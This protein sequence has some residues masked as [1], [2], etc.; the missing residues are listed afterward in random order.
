MKNLCLF[1]LSFLISTTLFSQKKAEKKH[2]S[3]IGL[4]IT[5]T[6]AGFFNAGGD[7]LPKDPFLFS[8]KRL[9]GGGAIRFGTNFRIVNQQ[10]FLNTGGQQ[11]S[12]ENDFF[13]RAGYEWRTSINRRFTLY[14]GLDGLLEYENETTTISDFGGENLTSSE[15]IYGVGGG[16]V[17]GILFHLN[18]RV[19]LSTEGTIYG[20]VSFTDSS[21]EIGN[22]LP[23]VENS[24]TDFR[25]LPSIPSS[26]YI[27]FSF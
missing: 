6:L 1:L 16:P 5:N 19:A 15:N 18:D 3:E 25:L 20:V 9:I 13:F 11:D 12:R 10:D 26:L 24:S 4:N 8:Y 22:G 21:Q 14:Y 27:I 23:P 2:S 17:L 7:D